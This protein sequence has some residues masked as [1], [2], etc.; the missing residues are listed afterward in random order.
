MAPPKVSLVYQPRTDER[1]GQ[2]VR[3]VTLWGLAVNLGLAAVKLTA[4]ILGRSQALVADAVHSISDSATDIAVV[5]GSYY[6]SEP[7]DAEHPYG[8][9]RIETLVTLLIGGAV[10][11]VGVFLT[12]EAIHVIRA[13]DNGPPAL[14]A[15]GAALVS[16][17]VKE[18][19]YRWTHRV[20]RRLR[21]PALR[22]NAWHHR[23]DAYSSIPVLLAIGGAAI[24]PDFWFLDPIG[25]IVVSGF[26]LKA[27]IGIARPGMRELIDSGAPP[28]TARAI[29]RVA[30]ETEGVRGIHDLRT[31]YVGSDIAADLHVE[32]GEDISVLEGH[33]I[34]ELVAER[35]RELVPDVVDV[36]VHI[37]PYDD[38]EHAR[39]RREAR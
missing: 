7:P 27:A 36:L 37:D 21:S 33:H 10:A 25:A 24:Y 22:A 23:T 29:E 15:A 3:R 19:L 1:V 39:A 12:W 8:H 31:R 38:R 2:E 16:I 35:V 34:A 30:L 13:G 32:V 17:V 4:G 11:L 18:L 5:V 26:I 28:E 6:W 14:A 20:G 9:R